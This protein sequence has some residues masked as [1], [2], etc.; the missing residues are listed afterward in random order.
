[1]GILN[2][3]RYPANAVRVSHKPALKNM[4]GHLLVSISGKELLS[5]KALSIKTLNQIDLSE[6]INLRSCLP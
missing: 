2:R 5:I 1:M 3:L 4:A 6:L